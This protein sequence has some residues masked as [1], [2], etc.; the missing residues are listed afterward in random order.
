MVRVC[1][2]GSRTWERPSS[3]FGVQRIALTGNTTRGGAANGR[4]KRVRLISRYGRP[5]FPTQL[6]LSQARRLHTGGLAAPASNGERRIAR[7]C[8]LLR[9]VT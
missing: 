9:V 6:E 8:V 4:Q 3:G 1:V 7:S 5:V 2:T